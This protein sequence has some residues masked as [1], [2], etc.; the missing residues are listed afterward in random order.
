[1]DN[2]I[3]FIIKGKDQLS[4]IFKDAGKTGQMVFSG[5]SAA[6]QSAFQQI[7]ND[8]SQGAQ[9]LLGAASAAAHLRTQLMG[10]SISHPSININTASIDK[11][12]A[13]IRG[14]Q[15]S[16]RQLGAGGGG[17]RIM[18]G[19]GAS[20]GFSGRG[21][22]PI[23][24][25]HFGRNG[26]GG[27]GGFFGK[28]S[29]IGN[30]GGGS[31]SNVL[32]RTGGS[33]SNGGGG[34]FGSMLGA[35]L[36]SRGLMTAMNIAKEM[37]VGTLEQGADTERQIVGLST[38][39][40]DKKA[41]YIYSQIQNQAVR[42]PFTSGL[43]LGGERQ[44]LPYMNADKANNDT[45]SL[46]NAVA[47]VGGS[48]YTLE[49][50]QMHMGQIAAGGK[51]EGIQA[52]EFQFAQIPIYKLLADTYFPKMKTPAA[53]EKLKNMTITYDMVS[54]ALKHAAETGGMFAGAMDK[55]SQTI[56]G[57][58]ST[59]MDFWQQGQSKLT[60]SQA[61]NI[62]GIED[63]MI[64][65]LE[66]I[67]ALV[68]KAAPYFEQ[69]F[70]TVRGFV[71]AVV[72]FGGAIA[73]ALKPIGGVLLSDEFATL[74][75]SV[76]GA[77]TELVNDLTPAIKALVPA[78]KATA[79]T[80]AML[81]KNGADIPG[82]AMY[83]RKG[84]MMEGI[85]QSMGVYREGSQPGTP[86]SV[87]DVISGIGVKGGIGVEKSTINPLIGKAVI[88]KY[89]SSAFGVQQSPEDIYNKRLMN[90][91]LG[92]SD[93]SAQA[94][95]MPFAM[96]AGDVAEGADKITGGGRKQVI[97]NVNKPFVG[98][99]TINAKEIKEGYVEMKNMV[100]QAFLEILG[101]ASG[102]IG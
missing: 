33:I 60:L 21:G 98:E 39:V 23:D 53:E 61:N 54:N 94:S 43:L 84:S 81:I 47:A 70:N 51:M 58:W 87:G 93:K 67:P 64:S 92:G 25:S 72:G 28:F 37:A 80:L 73:G 44:L 5:I 42:T 101:S 71:P 41:N 69:A 82:D 99:F 75:K 7:I 3:E 48:N 16:M 19:G 34:M 49:R 76:I 29:G 14:L 96:N 88:G 11:A 65:G 102:A 68:S 35:Q 77:S 55:L 27:G 10:I 18:I 91:Y 50:M 79:E 31:G 85:M 59:I 57:K 17:G 4:G 86:G 22:P 45:M 90:K 6:A 2:E 74:G 95:K 38:F 97:I 20:N 1:M 15:G 63:M 32:E 36:V 100:R 30:P 66:G 46:A 24:I 40:G 13:S 56:S 26:G 78:V 52:R 83:G 89:L 9:R 8:S 12:Q 62:K